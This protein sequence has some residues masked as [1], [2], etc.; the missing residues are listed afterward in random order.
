MILSAITGSEM[1]MCDV[2]IPIEL[3]RGVGAAQ[4]YLCETNKAQ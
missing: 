2:G 1:A 4:A 3:G